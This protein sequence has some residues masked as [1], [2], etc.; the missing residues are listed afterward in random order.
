M[1]TTI[2][3]TRRWT[4]AVE[5]ALCERFDVRLNP[6]DTPL[7]HDE[8][9]R[10]CAGATVLCPTGPDNVNRELIERLPDSVKLLANFGAGTNHID[11]AAASERGL[12]VSNTPGGV[13]DATADLTFGLIIATCRRFAEGVQMIRDD[14]WQ[15]WGINFMLGSQVSGKTLGIVGMGAIGT[16]V[17]K[18]ARGF[19][20]PVLYHNRQ[21]RP[22]AEQLTGASYCDTLETLLE[23]ADIVAL[24]CPL[25]PATHHLI[26]AAALQRM[27]PEAILINTARGPVVDEEALIVALR[28]G[29][30]AA[31]G[32]DVFEYEPR[33]PEELVQLPNTF[34]LPHMGTSTREARDAMGFIARDNIV[35]FLETGALID[36]VV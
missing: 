17:A 29:S 7:S 28:E 18:R 19:D 13:V 20:M 27:R 14:R 22:E 34:L 30:I 21:R 23:Q 5:A 1:T 35:R 25:T 11:V 9:V 15:G 4:P 26:D 36:P 16:A 2:V 12:L 31:A 24:T 33:V 10:R 8:I 3:L 6:E 32:L